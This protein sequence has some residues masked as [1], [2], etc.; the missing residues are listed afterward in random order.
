MLLCLIC[1][2]M[3]GQV[4][5]KVLIDTCLDYE[6]PKDCPLKEIRLIIFEKYIFTTFK[7]YFKGKRDGLQKD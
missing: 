7:K 3:Y 4:V 1:V 6:Y 2:Y 5:A